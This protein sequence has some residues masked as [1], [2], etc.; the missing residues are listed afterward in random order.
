MQQ[1]YAQPQNSFWRIMG[2]LVGAGPEHP[3]VERTQ[4]LRA[5]GVALWDVCRAAV[6]PGSLDTAIDLAT[7]VPNDFVAFFV[8]HPRIGLVCLNGGTAARL[9]ARLVVPRLPRQAA[10][11]P[12]IRL[13]STSPAHAALRFEQKLAL[14]EVVRRELGREPG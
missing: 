3:Y 4:R 11:L 7:V 13:P 5:A 14:W 8:A 2:A 12:T 1:Y 10:S 9:Y 6:R